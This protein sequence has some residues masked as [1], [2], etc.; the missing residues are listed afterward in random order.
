MF[1]AILLKMCDVEHTRKIW[2]CEEYSMMASLLSYWSTG[3]QLYR[4]F[5]WKKNWC[6]NNIH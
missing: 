3:R 2:I 6:L 5:M 1:I 4:S